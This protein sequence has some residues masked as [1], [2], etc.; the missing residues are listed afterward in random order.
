MQ[1]RQTLTSFRTIPAK[2]ELPV[3]IL[4]KVI[5]ATV[6]P[7]I[8]VAIAKQVRQG[9]CFFARF[10]FFALFLLRSLILG[11]LACLWVRSIGK[12][13]FRF[14]ISDFGFPNKTRNPKT[15][16]DKPKSFSKT[17]FN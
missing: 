5:A 12:S 3:S 2:T 1:R 4:M 10:Y 14:W 9:L 7:D 17:D 11:S 16:F 13:G 15:D 6:N 8:L